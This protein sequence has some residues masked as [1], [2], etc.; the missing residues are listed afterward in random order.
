MWALPIQI[1]PITPQI[2]ENVVIPAHA[3]APTR[4][5]RVV[6]KCGIYTCLAYH[7]PNSQSPRTR[8]LNCLLPYIVYTVYTI[9]YY[10]YYIY[11]CDNGR[12][13]RLAQGK[14]CLPAGGHGIGYGGWFAEPAC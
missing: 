3:A 5:G 14:Q 2:T 1:G 12:Y 13:G 6:N 11:M 9:L 7:L 4:V 10:I 8:S